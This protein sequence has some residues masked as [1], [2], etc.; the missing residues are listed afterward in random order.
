MI[1]V[2]EDSKL[3]V[4]FE[5]AEGE[6]LVR[7]SFSNLVEGVTGEEINQFVQ[8][9]DSLHELPTAYAIVTDSHRYIA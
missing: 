4:Y 2:W 6:K 7:Q 3:N 8:A 5:D 1:K 9:V